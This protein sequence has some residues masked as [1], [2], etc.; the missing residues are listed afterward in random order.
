MVKANTLEGYKL[1]QRGTLALARMEHNG[2]RIDV[3]YLDKMAQNLRADIAQREKR[4]DEHDFFRKWKARYGHETNY[5]SPDQLRVM[6]KSIGFK[7]KSLTPTLKMKVSADELS[8]IKED[9][10][11][12]FLEIK[13]K[14]KTL[15][16][17]LRGIRREVDDWGF[18]HP[19]YNLASG[20]DEAGGADSYRGSCSLP[21]FQNI[22]IRNPLMAG[23]I[24]P[25]FIPRKN[26][27][28][29]ERDFSGIEVRMAACYTRDKKLV[30]YCR[31]KGD[32]HHDKAKELFFLKDHEVDK[33][34]TRDAAKNRFVFP[35]FYGS[36]YFQCAPSL[37]E[38]IHQPHYKVKGSKE[39]I[40]ER[41]KKH[42]ITKLGNCD[43]NAP[44]RSGTFV[45]HVARVEKIMWEKT[46][47]E[48]TQWK[49]RWYAAYLKRGWFPLKTGFVCSG[50]YRRNQVLNF[51]IQGSAFHCLLWVICELQKELD[52]RK[53]RT[54]LIGQIHDSL[55]ADVP[56][57]ETQQYLDLTDE[58]MSKRLP[59][60]WDWINVPIETEVEVVPVG[61][62]WYEK[63]KW[64]KRNGRWALAI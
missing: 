22:P 41:L 29:I 39:T 35:E 15:N 14:L 13:K 55:L 45:A 10:V 34:T 11:K 33:R 64:E 17:Y 18:L 51:A 31:N 1:F 5:S 44:L 16:T 26:W 19:S 56:V 23:L 7:S 53:M 46:F 58:I 28:I 21:N 36:V 52:K 63:Q 2:I 40:L 9:F 37:W 50:Y 57:D 25:C 43:P 8:R 47:P 20:D 27:R 24:R 32:M 60:H 12:D 49:K 42:G 4:L 6:L 59:K 3:D 30:S 54:K 62:S 38:A 48:Y 61:K